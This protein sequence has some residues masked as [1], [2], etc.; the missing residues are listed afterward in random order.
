VKLRKSIHK[1]YAGEGKRM[2]KGRAEGQNG[3]MA[4]EAEGA[5]GIHHHRNLKRSMITNHLSKVP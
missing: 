2:V 5:K 1:V 4:E 3:G